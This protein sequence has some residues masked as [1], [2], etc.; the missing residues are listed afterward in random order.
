[1]TECWYNT[2]IY[3][4]LQA[5]AVLAVV[6]L[7]GVLQG[8]TGHVELRE[9]DFHPRRWLAAQVQGLGFGGSRLGSCNSIRSDIS[10]RRDCARK[11]TSEG[12]LPLLDHVA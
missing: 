9:L 5:L 3:V 2:R 12:G 1:M 6:V 11:R 7:V 4:R 8:R 10:R